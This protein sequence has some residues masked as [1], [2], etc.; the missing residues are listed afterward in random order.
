[1]SHFIF[2]FS[3]SNPDTSISMP[4]RTKL[5]SEKT[6]LVYEIFKKIFW[7][8]FCPLI[9]L[10]CPVLFYNSETIYCLVSLF[11]FIVFCSFFISRFPFYILSHCPTCCIVLSWFFRFAFLSLRIH[12]FSLTVLFIVPLVSALISLNKNFFLMFFAHKINKKWWQFTR[13][14]FYF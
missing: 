3:P 1:M 13:Y 11:S 8:L 9:C 10:F 6:K 12:Y 4:L 5:W 2:K 7:A 14:Y